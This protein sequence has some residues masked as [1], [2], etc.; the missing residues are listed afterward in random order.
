ML[1]R[2][3]GRKECSAQNVHTSRAELHARQIKS[4]QGAVLPQSP[5]E[6]FPPIPSPRLI[7]GTNMK[8]VPAS[9]L[10]R[11]AM[12][13]QRSIVGQERGQRSQRRR[14]QAAIRQNQVQ[15]RSV[16]RQA[17]RQVAG[18]LIAQRISTEIQVEQRFVPLQSVGQAPYA[19]GCV[20]IPLQKEILKA[21]SLVGGEACEG[22][23]NLVA[24]A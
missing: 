21:R 8:D 4:S 17:P 14:R 15:E 1:L 23:E 7:N 9:S 2:G 12:R 11:A 3:P 24:G 13:H 6:S 20:V 16:V 10:Q 5:R 18:T 22:P 19:R